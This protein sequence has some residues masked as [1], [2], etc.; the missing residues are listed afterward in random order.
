MKVLYDDFSF[1]ERYNNT[2]GMKKINYTFNFIA[3]L[4]HYIFKSIIIECNLNYVYKYLLFIGILITF[5]MCAK[6]EI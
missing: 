1:E 6:A 2:F 5:C 4:Y 3:I